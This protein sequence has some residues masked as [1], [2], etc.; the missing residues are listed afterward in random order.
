MLALRESHINSSSRVETHSH[1]N[2]LSTYDD[3]NTDDRVK[4]TYYAKKKC[5]EGTK[6]PAEKKAN[7]N[8]YKNHHLTKRQ[9]KINTSKTTGQK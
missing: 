7:R 5:R 3:T 9:N 8:Q 4:T 6:S 2:V 1:S